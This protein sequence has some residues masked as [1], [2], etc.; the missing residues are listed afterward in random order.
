MKQVIESHNPKTIFRQVFEEDTVKLLSCSVHQLQS[1]RDV[2]AAAQ[3]KM[4]ITK[5]ID[6]FDLN[7]LIIN[8][9]LVFCVHS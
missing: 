2:N 3:N 9:P 5:Q 8:C 6:K 1:F 7:G 4:V